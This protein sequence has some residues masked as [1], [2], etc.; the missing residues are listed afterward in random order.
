MW[1]G[2]SR[3]VLAGVPA[4]QRCPNCH[5]P[6]D[7]S[8]HVTGQRIPCRRCGLR[9]EVLR[10]DVVASEEDGSA[11]RRAEAA[12]PEHS[13]EE[14]GSAG[15]RAEAARPEHSKTLG[16]PPTTPAAPL[17][18][19]LE[20][21]VPQGRTAAGSGLFGA[22][23]IAESAR[24][25]EIPGFELI[26]VIGRGGMGEVWRA[27]QLSLGREVA[28]KMLA[29]QLAGEP[30]FVRRF[31]KEATALAALSHPHIVAIY[32]RGSSS[33]V[34]Y[35][36]MEL[37]TGP[38]LREK[39]AGGALPAA[40]ALGICAQILLAMDYAHARGIVHRDLKPENILLGT[41]E[42]CKV[43]DFGLA[44]VLGGDSLFQVTKPKVAMGTLSYMAPEQRRDAH[45]V[46]GRA[47]LYS[48][49]VVLYEL[50]T[51]ELPVGRFLLPSQRVPRLD[52]RIDGV[53]E[54]A[55]APAP[56]VR[57]QTA[58]ELGAALAAASDP[59]AAPSERGL[60]RWLKRLRS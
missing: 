40:E 6:H 21:T 46:D 50:L 25:L 56:A 53:L 27:R 4:K 42:G 7:I 38:S 2:R 55:L 58:R 16:S 20:Q 9:F 26:E 32:D 23:S 52:A 49:A 24:P 45:A 54:R 51:G 15:R 59:G 37:V 13:R 57:Y 34:Y 29:A 17:P 22:P 28:L 60:F 14:D 41:G 1:A 12:R 44:A 5:E 43:A 31:E 11:G 33:G 48:V 39:M 8:V 47:D 10:R 3:A 30:D 35:L 36:V 18:S 19:Y